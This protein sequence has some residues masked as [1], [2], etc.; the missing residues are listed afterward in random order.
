MKPSSQLSFAQCCGV[1]A[2]V[3]EFTKRDSDIDVD[4]YGSMLIAGNSLMVQ[5]NIVWPYSDPRIHDLT[6]E[7]AALVSGRREVGG[8]AQVQHDA[9]GQCGHQYGVPCEKAQRCCRIRCA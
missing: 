4:G 1:I 6:E 5:V 8:S 7:S 3:R 2:H 9:R